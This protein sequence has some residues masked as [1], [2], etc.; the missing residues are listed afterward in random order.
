V[1][2]APYTEYELLEIASGFK[3]HLKDH[4]ASIKSADPSLDQNFIYRFKALYYEIHTHKL[5]PGDENVTETLKLELK[6]FVEQIRN[7]IPIFRF[8]L[9]KAFPYNSNLWESYGY[10]EIEKMISDYSSLRKC[11]EGSVKLIYEKRTELR[12]VNCP[13][14]ILN[15]IENLSKQLGLK[16]EKLLNCLEKNEVRNSA[17]KTRINELFQ[18]MTIVHEAASKCL[19]KDPETLKYLTFP[20]KGQIH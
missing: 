12:A 16:H 7:L 9:Q 4:F 1:K 20:A 13:D 11:L 8:Y 5:T 14:S 3:K 17:Y 6:G 10:C 15:E 18:L 19:N 2:N